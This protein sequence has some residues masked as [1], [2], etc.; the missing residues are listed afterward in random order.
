[1]T[2]PMFAHDE[3]T[4]L[5]DEQ[6]VASLRDAYARRE[7]ARPNGDAIRRLVIETITPLELELVARGIPA[8]SIP[9]VTPA[10]IGA[11]ALGYVLP[12]AQRVAIEPS[13]V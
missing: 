13:E 6:V 3:F 9:P 7:A 8:Y 5:S 1:M 2:A 11:V 4:E 10:E 12:G